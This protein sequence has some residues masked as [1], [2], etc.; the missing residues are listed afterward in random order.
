MREDNLRSKPIIQYDLD[1]KLIKKCPCAE[2]V[3]RELKI[4]PSHIR[5]VCNGKRKTA[6]GFIWKNNL[7]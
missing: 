7:E 1:G 2:E 5:S 6:G 3:Y 4:N